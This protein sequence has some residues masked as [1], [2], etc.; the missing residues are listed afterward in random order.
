[1]MLREEVSSENWTLG[2]FGTVRGNTISISWSLKLHNQP[3]YNGISQ[4]SCTPVTRWFNLCVFLQRQR[5][6]LRREEGMHVPPKN[7]TMM[8]FLWTG[9][10]C[11][12]FAPSLFFF[13]KNTLPETNSSPLKIGLPNRKV[14]QY[15]NHRFLGA[16]MLL[17]GKVCSLEPSV[18]RVQANRGSQGCRKK[19]TFV[20]RF[21]RRVTADQ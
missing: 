9:Y 3:V 11:T 2:R 17:S 13:G 19:W 14:V 21:P 8:V 20:A 5:V 6:T 1:M 15:S 7:S 10:M 4:E 16:K 12:W 18:E